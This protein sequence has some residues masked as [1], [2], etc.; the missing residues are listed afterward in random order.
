MK[1]K[2]NPLFLWT[3]PLY[4]LDIG[5]FELRWMEKDCRG[6]VID[7]FKVDSFSTGIAALRQKTLDLK[8]APG[9]I[10]RKEDGHFSA[11]RQHNGNN[12]IKV[13]MRCCTAHTHA[14]LTIDANDDHGKIFNFH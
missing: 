6:K 5:A 3:P 8:L 10:Y 2:K 13:R 7:C 9:Y 14:T 1:K 12:P 11:I 4:Y